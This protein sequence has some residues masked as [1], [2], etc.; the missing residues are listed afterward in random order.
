MLDGSANIIL[1]YYFLIKNY[2]TK[3]NAIDSQQFYSKFIAFRKQLKKKK[4]LKDLNNQN[5]DRVEALIKLN[6]FKT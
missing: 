3:L 4:H 1:F 5:L 6:N 2:S